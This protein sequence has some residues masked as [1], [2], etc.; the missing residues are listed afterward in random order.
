MDK[1]FETKASKYLSFIL[2]HKPEAG[3]L[4]LDEEGY[5]SVHSVMKALEGAGYSMLFE[6]LVGLVNRDEKG[7]YSFDET[8]CYIRAN[9]GH[10]VEGI[11]TLK[12][13]HVIEPG[14]TF[15]HGTAFRFLKDIAYMGINKMSRTHVHLSQNQDTALEVGKRHTGG[16]ADYVAILVIDAYAMYVDGHQFFVSDNDVILVEDVPPKYVKVVANLKA[17]AG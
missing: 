10:S 6:D 7:R 5:A 11:D 1:K 4:T 14:A 17:F 9:Q 8:N 13:I 3:N 2:R 16:N 12:P 15:Y